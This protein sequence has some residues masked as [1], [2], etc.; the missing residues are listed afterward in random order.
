MTRDELR[1]IILELGYS[2]TNDQIERWHKAGIVP[3]PKRT[4]HK[5]IKGSKSEYP[6][7]AVH[8]LILLKTSEQSNRNLEGLLIDVWLRGGIVE[9]KHLRNVILNGNFSNIEKFVTR[10]QGLSEKL[11]TKLIEYMKKNPLLP[12]AKNID[13][14]AVINVFLSVLSPNKENSSWK[15][16]GVEQFTKEETTGEIAQ[17]VLGLDKLINIDSDNF[18]IDQIYEDLKSSLNIKELRRSVEEASEKEFEQVRKDFFIL[19]RIVRALSGMNFIGNNSF[20]MLNLLNNRFVGKRKLM[21]HLLLVMNKKDPQSK[22]RVDWEENL[23]SL[24]LLC[25]YYQ[26]MKKIPQLKK[27]SNLHQYFEKC[28]LHELD[29]IKTYHQKYCEQNPEFKLLIENEMKK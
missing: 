22:W 26:H 18:H 21:L 8:N 12:Y 7:Y 10:Y 16:S 14:I 25:G 27:R 9:E 23:S 5:G 29:I 20:S 3:A 6:N 13:V 11:E 17:R 2:V 19:E 24:E 15:A 28:S 1:E 4:H